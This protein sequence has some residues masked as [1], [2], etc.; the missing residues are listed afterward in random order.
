MG[1]GTVTAKYA[2]IGKTID[3]HVKVVF[4]T[5][6]SMGTTPSFTLPV[7][8]HADYVNGTDLMGQ[9]GCH[10]SGT[11]DFSGI[12]RM[13]TGSIVLP[14]VTDV[15]GTYA[16]ETGLTSAVPMTWTT[17]DALVASGT[18]EAA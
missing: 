8:P 9:C 18:Y 15:S 11:A 3:W 7:A 14:L 2:R 12:V 1:N 17:G 16:G 10:D 4:G 13:S 6:S 5:T